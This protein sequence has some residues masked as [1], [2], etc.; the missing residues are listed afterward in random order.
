MGLNDWS[1]VRLF[2]VV[3]DYVVGVWG[4][5]IPSLRRSHT[6]KHTHMHNN[7]PVLTD[8]QNTGFSEGPSV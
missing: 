8:Q 2:F 7:Q 4:N 1:E 3:T 6:N 5:V